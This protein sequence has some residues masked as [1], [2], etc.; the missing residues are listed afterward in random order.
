MKDIF[1]KKYQEYCKTKESHHDIFKIQ[2]LEDDN[3]KD[4]MERFSYISQK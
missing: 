3:L 4:Y 2:Q 1:L